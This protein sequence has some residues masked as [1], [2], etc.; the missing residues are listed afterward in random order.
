[1]RKVLN[2]SKWVLLGIL[3]VCPALISTNAFATSFTFDSVGDMVA[4]NYSLDIGS[5]NILTGT[6]KYTAT[7]ISAN[8]ITLTTVVTNTSTTG[9]NQG[10]QS[11]GFKTTDP[12]LQQAGSSLSQI[13]GGS[14]TFIGLTIDGTFPGFQQVELCAWVGNNCSGGAQS[15]AVKENNFD[16]FSLILAF[17]PSYQ[18]GQTPSF[19][20]HGPIIRYKGDLGSFT[21][22]GTCGPNDPNCSPTP[23]PSTVLLFG[24]G[25]TGLILW[26]WKHSKK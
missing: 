26:R 5:G 17:N 22:E 20:V 13:A 19:T 21:F 7:A 15:Q 23:E 4:F 25:L 1:M 10:I 18:T 11:V 12:Q 14:G 16:N 6:T 3:S 9:T 8:S 2:Y 24:S